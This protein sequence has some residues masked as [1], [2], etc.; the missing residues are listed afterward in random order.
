M[1]FVI[2]SNISQIN[3]HVI[4]KDINH[5]SV[6]FP[7][8]GAIPQKTA[9]ASAEPHLLLSLSFRAECSCHFE[10]RTFCHFE[11]SPKGEVEKSVHHPGHACNIHRQGLATRSLHALLGRD[12]IGVISSNG[13]FVILL[14]CV[15]ISISAFFHPL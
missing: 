12:D 15:R 3:N 14:W 9:S 13:L 6:T 5:H 11:R 7:I 10:Q 1:S 8:S 4:I 2:L